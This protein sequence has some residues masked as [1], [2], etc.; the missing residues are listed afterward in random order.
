MADSVQVD[1]R[2]RL[3]ADGA[4]E[5][6]QGSVRL[7]ARR[8]VYDP[9]AGSLE[10]AGPMVLSDGPDR[11]LLSDTA[12]LS[13][14]LRDG[15]LR[16]ARVVL[17]QQ[18][19]IAADRVR[20]TDGRLLQME[21]AIASS[22]TVCAANPTPLWEVRAARVTHDRDRQRLE[23]ERAEF[24]LRGVPLV[25]VPRLSLPDGTVERAAGVLRPAVRATSEL[26]LHVAVPWFIPFGADRDLT[27]SPMLGTTGVAGVGLRWRQ[28][29]DRGGVDLGGLVSRDRER[30]GRLRGYGYLRALIALER[31][32]ELEI[33]AIQPGDRTVLD[34]YDVTGDTRLR[35]HA[36][37]RRIRRD[38]AIRARALA[39]RSLEPEAVNAELPGRVL[40]A[41]WE[42]RWGGLPMGGELT[43]TGRLHAHQRP[44]RIDGDR[45]RD[46]ARAALFARWQ[47]REVLA[48]GI[49]GQVALQGRLDHVRIGDDLRW[50]RPVNR[51]A[52]EAMVELRWPWVGQ[53]RAGGQQVI[54]PIAQVIGARRSRAALPNDD[55]LLPELD[56]G[57]LFAPIRHAGLDA[58]DDGTRANLGLRWMRHAPSGI[59][60]ESLVGRVWRH[61]ALAGFAPDHRQ[62]LGAR[63]SDWLL[64]GR[65]QT[66]RGLAL[67][68][69]A[70]VDDR[71]DVSRAEASASLTRDSGTSFSTRYLYVAANPAESRPRALNEWSL[72]IAHRFDSGWRGRV[73]WD[74]DLGSRNWNAARAALEFRNECLL[75][76]LS[77]SRRFAGSTSLTASTRLGLTVELLG[78]SGPGPGPNARA[79]RS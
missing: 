60:V 45:G 37:I 46:V 67:G 61:Q 2:G 21:A 33:D 16:S 50:P 6:W 59:S 9:Q 65:L 49:L 78:L 14:D 1:A 43:L 57:N 7:T 26:G 55:H 13:P 34:T 12:D 19:Q 23:F 51:A 31:G 3:V 40:Q 58:P 47:R 10:I 73:G 30:P 22:C 64:A 42:Q 15:L 39:F 17:N 53:D 52:A 62:P 72:D 75:F 11:L 71:G 24:R 5:I 8:V 48:G 68:L 28:A 25:Q 29:W 38:Q 44:A 4:V 63:R 74:Y 56:G 76:D 79:C 69:R 35:S 32:F 66:G 36:T 41:D 70:L 27:L 18:L 20:R 77:L 54:E